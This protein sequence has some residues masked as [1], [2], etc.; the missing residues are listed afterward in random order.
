MWSDEGRVVVLWSLVEQK[1]MQFGH[2]G[3]KLSDVEEWVKGEL[4]FLNAY[5]RC[6]QLYFLWLRQVLLQK[7]GGAGRV[8]VREPVAATTV[9]TTRPIALFGTET[10][11]AV[12]GPQTTDAAKRIVDIPVITTTPIPA[13]RRQ[14][15]G[16]A[17]LPHAIRIQRVMVW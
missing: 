8:V 14:R 13:A 12:T 7:R 6:L 1:R 2:V 4:C 3:Q 5:L 11:T 10:M 17:Q 9:V 15:Q 16:A